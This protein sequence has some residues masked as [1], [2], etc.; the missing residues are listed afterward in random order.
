M[1]TG[2]LTK[3]GDAKQ[4]NEEATAIEKIQ[5]EV[6]GSY[7]LD[8]KMDKTQL[9]NNLKKIQGIEYN[10]KQIT[11][12]TIINEFPVIV[13]VD[14]NNIEINE[15]GQVS[16]VAIGNSAEIAGDSG[17]IGKAVNYEVDYSSIGTGTGWQ[18]LYADSKNVYIITTGYLTATALWSAESSAYSGTSDFLD[19]T[20]YPAVEDGWL[21]KVYNDGTLLYNSNKHNMKAT[22][23][24]LNSN[25]SIW[26][27][28]KNDKA[29]WSI[30]SPTME[31]LV[32]S[33]NAVNTSNKVTIED[34]VADGNGYNEGVIKGVLTK[35][36]DRPWN[37]GTDYWLA[38][39]SGFSQYNISIVVGSLEGSTASKQYNNCY[40]IRP[41]ICLK[42]S[43]VLTWNDSTNKYDLSVAK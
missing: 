38:T 20:N 5:V 6:A 11:N 9:V 1:I 3:A 13:N 22:E 8:G 41:V 37:H 18:I 27:D 4:A 29:K 16:K 14:G 15:D 33:Y 35:T 24:L 10:S 19:L 28:L 25:I 17:N 30:G 31:L 43:T 2:L 26:K 39:P 40:A 36:D 12:D 32:A 7:G 21:Y 42:S 23:S 34:L